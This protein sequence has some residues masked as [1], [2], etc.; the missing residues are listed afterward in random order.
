MRD[1]PNNENSTV[2]Q[3]LL[4]LKA[5]GGDAEA[6]DLLI[7]QIEQDHTLRENADKLFQSHQYPEHSLN[8]FKLQGDIEFPRFLSPNAMTILIAM[9]QNMQTDNLL[10]VSRRDLIDITHL[11]SLKAVQPAL[12]E[13]VQNGCITEVIEAS[14]RRSAVYMV[15][16]EIATVG[17]KKPHLTYLFWKKVR[18]SLLQYEA[19]DDEDEKN[20]DWNDYPKS[21][22]RNRWVS[23]TKDKTYS[24]G[25][26]SWKEG[27]HGIRYNKIRKLEAKGESVAKTSLDHV[28]KESCT[29][30]HS[31]E[32]RIIQ[33]TKTTASKKK[34]K[35]APDTCLEEDEL[36]WLPF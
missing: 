15:N 35:A 3:V 12:K 30:S 27:A 17:K 28:S 25:T 8:W 4:D 13:L 19:P 11:T 34:L 5:S 21:P 9:C 23:L 22:I 31:R 7:S 32:S 16:P 6:I 1:K 14:G 2:K 33:F 18:N 36:S 24:K 10:Q 20:I 26:E 29:E